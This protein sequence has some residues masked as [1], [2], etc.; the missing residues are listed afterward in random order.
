MD[1]DTLDPNQY[2][3]MR[4]QGI[5]S[6]REDNREPFPHKFETTI[7]IPK[8]IARYQDVPEGQHDDKI[9][10]RIAGTFRVSYWQTVLSILIVLSQDQ[11]RQTQSLDQ[12]NVIK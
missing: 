10:E 1:E 11:R 3:E 12:V 6:A 5:R 2:Y 4:V 7:Q 9:T 8:F